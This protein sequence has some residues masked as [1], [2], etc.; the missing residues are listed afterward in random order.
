MAESATQPTPGAVRRRA[1]WA[2]WVSSVPGLFVRLRVGRWRLCVVRGAYG[3]GRS[4]A[5]DQ[6]GM[7]ARMFPWRD[8]ETKDAGLQAS[9]NEGYLPL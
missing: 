6:P 2:A 7:R 1:M 9:T 5:Q 8:A 3:P 4:A